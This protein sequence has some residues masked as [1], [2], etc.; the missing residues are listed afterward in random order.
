MMSL[1]GQIALALMIVLPA[2]FKTIYHYT[3]DEDIFDE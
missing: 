3:D 2:V 1:D